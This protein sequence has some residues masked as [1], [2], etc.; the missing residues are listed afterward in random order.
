MLLNI[1]LLH[2]A[3]INWQTLS[4]ATAILQKSQLVK[5]DRTSMLR[6]YM[7]LEESDKK[8]SSTSPP[9]YREHPHCL[10]KNQAQLDV[11]EMHQAELY[12]TA[13]CLKSTH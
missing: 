3:R 7:Q 5:M 4:D 13:L 1:A 10:Q 8:A 2:G 12:L 11:E 6:T 9:I